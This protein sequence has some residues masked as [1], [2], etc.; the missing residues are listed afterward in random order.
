MPSLNSE[1][2][3]ASKYQ[4]YGKYFFK[5]SGQVLDSRPGE[6]IKNDFLPRVLEKKF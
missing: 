1:L 5:I 6:E 3:T 2:A 4:S